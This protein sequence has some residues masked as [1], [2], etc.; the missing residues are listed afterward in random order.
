MNGHELYWEIRRMAVDAKISVAE[1]CS[2]AEVNHATV[3]KWKNQ[4]DAAPHMA[5]ILQLTAATERLTGGRYS[6]LPNKIG[7]SIK[8]KAVYKSMVH[9]CHGGGMP[10]YEWSRYGGRGITVCDEWR[11]NRQTFIDWA[12]SAGYQPGLQLD[13]I[14]NDGNYE[15]SNCRFVTAKENSANRSIQIKRA[16]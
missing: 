14:N 2:Q 4:Q 15:P 1:L 12:L 16:A 7:Y 6:S 3:Y 13:R 11:S 8:L 9:R 5:T 10:A